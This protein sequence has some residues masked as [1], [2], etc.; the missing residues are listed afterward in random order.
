[1][2]FD[3][4]LK[5]ENGQG[6]YRLPSLDTVFVKAHALI[7]TDKQIGAYSLEF[8]VNEYLGSLD[9][10]IGGVT[11][12]F[13]EQG[14]HIAVAN[15]IAISEVRLK[16]SIRY[17]RSSTMRCSIWIHWRHLN[18]WFFPTTTKAAHT[19]AARTYCSK[20]IA[21]GSKSCHLVDL[22]NSL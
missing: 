7:F 22:I 12:K 8:A 17:L 16:D 19:R 18:L 21:L 5:P 9:H 13:M 6:L 14:Y 4:V 11:S 10:H 2:S 1:M 15:S 3:P 20:G